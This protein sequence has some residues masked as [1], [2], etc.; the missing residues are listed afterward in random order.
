MTRPLHLFLHWDFWGTPTW[1]WMW[2]RWSHK[3][4]RLS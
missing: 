4:D 2:V 3:C 1:Q